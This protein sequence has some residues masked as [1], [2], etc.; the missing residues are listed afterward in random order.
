MLAIAFQTIW[1]SDLDLEQIT[2]LH[3]SCITK[4]KTSSRQQANPLNWNIIG[5]LKFD[6]KGFN[7]K[8]EKTFN[9]G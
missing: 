8:A 4:L 9:I 5:G 1:K 3:K 6:P 2:A 7:D